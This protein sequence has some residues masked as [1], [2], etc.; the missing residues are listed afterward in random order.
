MQDDQEATNADENSIY[1][2]IDSTLLNGRRFISNEDSYDLTEI[3]EETA[4]NLKNVSYPTPAQPGSRLLAEYERAV[5]T[6]TISKDT[7]NP[8]VGHD[9]SDDD[10]TDCAE[11]QANKD[12]SDNDD[13]NSSDS[14][15]SE[16]TQQPQ[17][18]IGSPAPVCDDYALAMALHN[19][20]QAGRINI[21]ELSDD[22]DDNTNKL[23][24]G[25]SSAQP[26]DSMIESIEP[27]EP[28][29]DTVT[30]VVAPSSKNP[31]GISEVM[32]I[33]PIPTM[34]N[35]QR[36]SKYIQNYWKQLK[37][38]FD[39]DMAKSIQSTKEELHSI[40]LRQKDEFISNINNQ[41][42]NHFSSPDSKTFD[43][44]RSNF[45]GQLN[46]FPHDFL[47]IIPL[48]NTSK[49]LEK[50]DSPGMLQ[51]IHDNYV[52]L[53]P[54]KNKMATNTN[55]SAL[56]TVVSYSSN[57]STAMDNEKMVDASNS[58]NNTTTQQSISQIGVITNGYLP[59]DSGN[60]IELRPNMNHSLSRNPFK[61]MENVFTIS[62][63]KSAPTPINFVEKFAVSTLFSNVVRNSYRDSTAK[64]DQEFEIIRKK[65]ISLM[66]PAI[67]SNFVFNLPELPSEILG[68]I[69]LLAMPTNLNPS[70]FFNFGKA[71]IRRVLK[72]K[73]N[74]NA[75]QKGD[76]KKKKKSKKNK[77]PKNP[78]NYSE[79]SLYVNTYESYE[80]SDSMVE[81]AVHGF[82]CNKKAYKCN[83]LMVM[84]HLLRWVTSMRLVCKAMS[85]A[86]T[87]FTPS[88][89]FIIGFMT[90]VFSDG[91]HYYIPEDTTDCPCRKPGGKKIPDLFQ[92]DVPPVGSTAGTP[93]SATC[94]PISIG[95]NLGAHKSIKELLENGKGPR[96]PDD[97]A[98][99]GTKKSKVIVNPGVLPVSG[100]NG[101]EGKIYAWH[102][103]HLSIDSHDGNT[104]CN[105][106]FHHLTS[107]MSHNDIMDFMSYIVTDQKEKNKEWLNGDVIISKKAHKK[108][109]Q[110]FGEISV[111]FMST[112]K[113]TTARNPDS[114]KKRKRG[115]R[116]HGLGGSYS[117]VIGM[118]P[119][120]HPISMTPFYLL[121]YS[122]L[123]KIPYLPI[124]NISLKD[125][126]GN[127]KSVQL[128][129]SHGPNYLIPSQSEVFSKIRFFL[130][131][132]D[133]KKGKTTNFN[134]YNVLL[135]LFKEWSKTKYQE[136]SK[137]EKKKT[138]K[139]KK[140]KTKK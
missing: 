59:I 44:Y 88:F 137:N 29:K 46:S 11:Q 92:I 101:E 45:F 112:I 43:A 140:S 110:R 60:S 70:Q 96:I 121:T 94:T 116:A 132:G 7:T 35:T 108:S 31:S 33:Q 135:T 27:Q 23:I 48:Q 126:E 76:K 87:G 93:V 62:A 51:F 32:L 83:R 80:N 64:M 78:I 3:I 77:T 114:T 53:E 84:I 136:P 26:E 4:R 17:Q 107:I 66:N 90:Q 104:C 102:G 72:T 39:D 98:K 28:V 49:L 6:T 85:T 73:H 120:V 89:P 131:D 122:F 109:L 38:K 42:F 30:V 105:H 47:S 61:E 119:E 74:P 133:D 20:E 99:K 18:R 130:K 100:A 16:D 25:N 58:S 134:D 63:F 97:T 21:I 52:D 68:R 55:S 40:L 128:R 138:K 123:D 124:Y 127:G 95:M 10:D 82:V 129:F 5:T 9:D 111:E 37:T 125:A 12:H 54:N 24:D 1:N 8:C 118:K 113:D 79:E 86:I 75:D 15:D 106:W 57:E 139:E 65:Q 103:V 115:G 69:L 91:A 22:E 56:P 67:P 34:K 19:E 117:T 50:S 13:D 71:S 41:F 81:C 2:L 14:S 36:V